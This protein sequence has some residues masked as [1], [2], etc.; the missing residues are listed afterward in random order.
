MRLSYDD[1]EEADFGDDLQGSNGVKDIS[2]VAAEILAKKQKQEE[3]E[4]LRFTQMQN[5]WAY[6]GTPQEGFAE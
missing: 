5:F 4:R 3:E 2:P 1:L 6:D